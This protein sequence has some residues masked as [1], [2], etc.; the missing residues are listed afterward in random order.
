MPLRFVLYSTYLRLYS[1]GVNDS[2]RLILRDYEITRHNNDNNSNANNNKIINRIKPKTTRY[3]FTQG[4][5]KK[6]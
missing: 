3:I 4:K 6:R 5:K 2:C 1:V